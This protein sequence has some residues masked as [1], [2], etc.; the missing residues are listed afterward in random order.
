MGIPYREID[1]DTQLVEGCIKGDSDAWTA[2]VDKYGGY[3]YGIIRNKLCSSGDHRYVEDVNDVF[4]S[5]FHTL[6]KNDCRALGGVRHRAR[7]ASWLGA[8]AV[9]RSLDFLRSRGVERRV[10]NVLREETAPYTTPADG[11]LDRDEL[12]QKIEKVLSQLP[13]QE[14]LTVNLFYIHGKRYREIA[15]ITGVPVNT[16]SS[17]LHRAKKRVREILDE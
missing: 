12:F 6:L 14:Q 4:Q 5:V 10:H 7:I 1:D 17:R 11:R 9:N 15:E 13:P 3:V 8:I 2:L 16:V